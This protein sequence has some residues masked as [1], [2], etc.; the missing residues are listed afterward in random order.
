VNGSGDEEV[1]M[2]FYG[3]QSCRT[4]EGVTFLG[5]ERFPIESGSN[6]YGL[7]L[8]VN[9]PDDDT[10]ITAD[11]DQTGRGDHRILRLRHL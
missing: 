5:S 8:F 11:L 2:D 7:T 3:S 1:E 9:V 10:A 4:G 6:P